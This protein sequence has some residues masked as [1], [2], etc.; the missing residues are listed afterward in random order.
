[1]RQVITKISKLENA[2]IFL[3]PVD[4]VSYPEYYEI[5]QSPMD[6]TT[7]K[8]KLNSYISVE[9]M[10]RD[11]RQ[12]WENCRIFNADGSDIV[13]M[14]DKLAEASEALIEVHSYSFHQYD[15]S[16]NHIC[17]TGTSWIRA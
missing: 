14:A 7:V 16:Y 13:K 11:I 3:Y 2:D 8:N 5:I 17:I 12:I 10:L 4:S 1:M 15:I 9:E 6:I